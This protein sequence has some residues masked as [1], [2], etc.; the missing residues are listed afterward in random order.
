MLHLRGRGRSC[1]FTK[2]LPSVLCEPTCP[3][4]Q[5]WEGA[6]GPPVS[7]SWMA[8]G[9]L[10]VQGGPL[11]GGWRGNMKSVTCVASDVRRT[12]FNIRL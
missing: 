5:S 3:G 11:T 6:P 10:D 9:L 4:G 8:A 12:V 1:F 2:M 7:Q